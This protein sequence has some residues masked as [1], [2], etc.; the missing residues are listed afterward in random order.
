M[1]GKCKKCNGKG[2]SKQTRTVFHFKNYVKKNG[3]PGKRMVT[4]SLGSGCPMCLGLGFTP[5]EESND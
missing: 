2:Q 5:C 3:K 1:S 4:D